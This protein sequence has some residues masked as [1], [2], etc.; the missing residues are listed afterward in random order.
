MADNEIKFTLAQDERLIRTLRYQDISSG[1]ETSSATI[2]LTNK[3]L[4]HSYTSTIKKFES[5]MVE[6][7]PVS[8][9]DSI[10]SSYEQSRKPVN[11]GSVILGILVFLA[12]IAL[13]IFLFGKMHRGDFLDYVGYVIAA[14]GVL[15]VILAFA[16]RK[17]TYAFIFKA[18][19]YS[20][21]RQHLQ[22]GV[23]DL[24]PRKAK[25]VEENNKNRGND[26]PPTSV[27]ISGTSRSSPSTEKK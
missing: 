8:L 1:G 15:F 9:I 2:Y 11:I 20:R 19:S 18:I 6:E 22:L 7:M 17:K 26:A 21:D 16:L 4:I 23:S 10:E 12:G 13:Q 3:R 27:W 14:V 25:K 24:N 5:R